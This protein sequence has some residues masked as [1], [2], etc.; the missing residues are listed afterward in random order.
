MRLLVKVRKK[1]K[2]FFK[3]GYK[4]AIALRNWL[5]KNRKK[6]ILFFVIFI[7]LFF[8]F[9]PEIC[10]A[11]DPDSFARNSDFI[12]PWRG[13]FTGEE[14]DFALILYNLTEAKYKNIKALKIL[15]FSRPFINHY[16]K[17]FDSIY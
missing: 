13:L 8:L 17:V 16:I 10:F 4:L 2:R 5:Y 6:I 14:C 12:K 15:S 11:F 9:N 7:I 3:R 1:I